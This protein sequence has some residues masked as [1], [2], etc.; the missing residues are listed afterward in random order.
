MKQCLGR[1]RQRHELA[2]H[3]RLWLFDTQQAHSSPSISNASEDEV[4]L[5]M[6]L[7]N[8]KFEIFYNTL[9]HIELKRNPKLVFCGI[10]LL[11]DFNI[12]Y[13]YNPQLS[14]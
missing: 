4:V 2:E 14:P 12:Q 10:C 7:S 3:L 1:G 5:I 13:W 6:L 11:F 8:N 9:N